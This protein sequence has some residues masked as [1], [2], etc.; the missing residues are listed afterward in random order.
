MLGSGEV[1]GKCKLHMLWNELLK[2]G[3]EPVVA[4]SDA[5]SFANEMPTVVSCRM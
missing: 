5:I 4:L 2:H 1:I 3:D